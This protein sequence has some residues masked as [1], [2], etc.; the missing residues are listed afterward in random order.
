MSRLSLIYVDNQAGTYWSW[1]NEAPVSLKVMTAHRKFLTKFS[2]LG[3]VPY[4]NNDKTRIGTQ[5]I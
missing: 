2:P 5:H 1:Q 3:T 4:W